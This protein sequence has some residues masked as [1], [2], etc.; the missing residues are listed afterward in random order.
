MPVVFIDNQAPAKLLAAG[1]A[2]QAA[3][4]VDAAT[5]LRNEVPVDEGT[6]KVHAAGNE[7]TGEIGFDSEDADHWG[8]VNNGTRYVTAQHFVESAMNQTAGRL[9]DHYRRAALESFR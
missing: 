5:T 9:V 8:F 2:G 3:A 1:K 6:L 7:E 4:V